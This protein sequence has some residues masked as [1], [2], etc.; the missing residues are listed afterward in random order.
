MLS[1]T[2]PSLAQ[3]PATPQYGE[4]FLDS[5][6]PAGGQRG[7]SVTVEIT[8]PANNSQSTPLAGLSGARGLVID[9]PA[10][11]TVREVK[12]LSAQR[13]QAVLDIAADAAPGRSMI[14]VH[15][16]RSGL[17]SGIWFVVGSLPE[18][19]EVEPNPSRERSQLVESPAVVNGR[20]QEPLD[21]DCFRFHAQQGES[22]VAAINAH[23][24]DRISRGR[25]TYGYLDFSL[26]VLGPDGAVVAEAQ[27]TFGLDPVVN[28]TAP[29][30]GEYTAKVFLVGYLGCP[31]AV[32]R[33]T[34]GSVAYPTAVFPPGGKRGAA[35][36]LLVTGP[37]VPAGTTIPFTAPSDMQPMTWFVPPDMH[38]E[39]PYVLGDRDESRE[40]EPN[41]EAAQANELKLG[42]TVNGLFDQP[43][44]VDQFQLMLGKK[45]RVRLDLVA[46]RFLREGVDT[47]LEVYD[48]EGTLLATN[49]DVSLTDVEVQHDFEPFD[50]GLTFDSTKAGRYLVKVSEQ[51]GAA[52]H[53]AAYR[54]T[55]FEPQPEFALQHWPDAVPIWGPGSTAAFIVT[56]D[57][58]AV[59][60]QKDI[61][62]T[63][64]DLPPGWKGSTSVSLG[65]LPGVARNHG[66][67]VLMTI[68][69]PRD[70][71][72]GTI[73]TFRVVGRVEVS[74]KVIERVAQ[75]VTT[76]ITTDRA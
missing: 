51:T 61:T 14:R 12:N 75:P 43:G 2:D 58:Q 42:T 38:H 45:Q 9:G 68:T 62:L 72:V 1:G 57:R 16:D 28:F 6:Y 50:S 46:Q 31:E 11:I 76:Y 60:G 26:E 27:D 3:P 21:I 30:T 59:V 36:S 65:V 19:A 4:L 56:V 22:I 20:I 41:G 74:G 37:N 66:R 69:A 64:E 48:A 8:G 67:R 33:L 7:Q 15:S 53:R 24:I 32:Y 63:V 40:Q 29:T 39:V 55:S 52:G 71:P 73:A 17:S 54:L 35:T 44:D 23:G 13:V 18:T 25:K 70:V 10:G 5:I 34:L 47:L 49:D